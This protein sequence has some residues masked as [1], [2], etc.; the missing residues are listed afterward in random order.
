MSMNEIDRIREEY[1]RRAQ[2]TPPEFYSRS[3]PA[4]LFSVQQRT[5]CCLRLLEKGGFFPLHD[6]RILDVGC[7]VGGWLADLES[8]GAQRANLAGID[9]NDRFVPK[10][11]RRLSEQRDERGFVIAPGADIRLGDASHLLWP[12]SSFDIVL[13]STVFTSILDESMRRAVAEE[14]MRVLKPG[15]VIIWYDF[16]CNN[17]ANPNVRGVGKREI[18]SLFHDCQV[19]LWRIT[20]APPIA[21]RLVSWAWIAGLLLEK[22]RFLNTHYFGLIRKHQSAEQHVEAEASLGTMRV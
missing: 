4:N 10:A 19:R 14:M 13:Q 12:D 3:K 22:L 20:L 21:R 15:G 11:R 8:W 9:L 5:R 16:L 18:T 6:K 1:H 2:E 17:P 7:G